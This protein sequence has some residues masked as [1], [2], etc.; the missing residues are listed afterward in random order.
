MLFKGIGF[1]SG[2]GLEEGVKLVDNICVIFFN[3]GLVQMFGYYNLNL[4]DDICDL[5]GKCI[6][7]GLFCGV[8]LI[9]GCV[10]IQLLLGVVDGEGYEG[11]Q[12]QWLD[13]VLVIIG[14]GIDVW[15]IFEGLLL[16]CQIVIVVVGGIIIYDVLFDFLVSELG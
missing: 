16:G 4:I 6:W 11:V 1:Y 7:N 15:I 9:F 5:F 13:I 12:N 2:V 10:M 3:V 8:V 14:G